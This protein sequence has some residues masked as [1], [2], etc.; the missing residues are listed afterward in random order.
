MKLVWLGLSVVCAGSLVGMVVVESAA[1][2]L[3]GQ[4]G[5]EGWCV[6]TGARHKQLLLL[7]VA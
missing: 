6:R 2:V 4:A 1:G 5:G 7:Q 3:V